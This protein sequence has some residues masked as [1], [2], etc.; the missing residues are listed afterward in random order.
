[1]SPRVTPE[2]R[3]PDIVAAAIDVFSR[4]GYRMT[5]MEE[6]AEQ[7][8]VS[9]ATLY[10][11]FKSKLHLF[12]YVLENGSREGDRNAPPPESSLPRSE[13]DF[14]RLL[15]KKL[16]ESTRLR[17]VT[18]FLGAESKSI[19]LEKEIAEIVEELWDISERNRIQIVIL[20]KSFSEFPELGE[21][22]D[23][24]GRGQMLRQLERYLIGRIRQGKIRPLHS[25]PATARFMLESLAWF[26]FKQP[27]AAG[28]TYP[29]EQAL[30][31]LIS[32]FVAGLQ[33]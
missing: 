12:Q 33:T 24:H 25:V 11:Y 16:K 14:L 10:Y 3:I 26:G 30:P 27:G 32:I 29:R 6:V 20:E 7:A 9:K 19:D 31:D 8:G 28:P 23:R 15:K 17:S 4:K 13:D 5:Q 22:Y 1:M 18:S 21:V 2:N